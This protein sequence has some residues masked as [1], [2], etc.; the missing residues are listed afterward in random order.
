M[1]APGPISV[2]GRPGMVMIITSPSFSDLPSGRRDGFPGPPP[3]RS[4]DGNRENQQSGDGA[5]GRPHP[6]ERGPR[7]ARI[8]ALQRRPDDALRGGC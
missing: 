6:P 2:I 4:A 3:N 5:D 7:A 1:S 8:G